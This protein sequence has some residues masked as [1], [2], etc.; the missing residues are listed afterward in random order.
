M[1]NRVRALFLALTVGLSVAACGSKEKDKEVPTVTV[2]GILP[3][4]GDV[5]VETAYIGT[6]EPQQ[7]VTVFPMVSGNVTQLQ[8]TLRQTVK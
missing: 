8:A 2:S 7:S 1:K 5:I 3:A 6:V 4:Q